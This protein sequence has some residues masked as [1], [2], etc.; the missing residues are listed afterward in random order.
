MERRKVGTDYI[1]TRI[2][3]NPDVSHRYFRS[4]LPPAVFPPGA[5]TMVYPPVKI[6]KT[7]TIKN[8]P[9]V[10][11]AEGNGDFNN[12]H[13]AAI[14]LGVP[15]VLKR[16]L[17]VVS[18]GG[19]KTYIFLVVVLGV[20]LIVGYWTAM[21]IYGKRKNEKVAIPAVNIEEFITT[22]DPELKAKYHDKEK[23]PMQV[24]YDAYF[25]GKYEFNGGFPFVNVAP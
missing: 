5:T 13:L 15:W 23:I 1:T 18:Y 19:F 8:P 25:D 21:S 24:F 6:S 10:G 7:P 9:L 11:V 12:L 14:V 4:W 16:I 2:R 20:P 3:G 17:P 22:D